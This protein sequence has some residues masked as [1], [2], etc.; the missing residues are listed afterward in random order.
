MN[1]QFRLIVFANFYN[2]SDRS[3]LWLFRSNENFPGSQK[4]QTILSSDT[5]RHQFV[6]GCRRIKQCSSVCLDGSRGHGQALQAP[7]EHYIRPTLS[8]DQPSRK[9]RRQSRTNCK[10]RASEQ[11]LLYPWASRSRRRLRAATLLAS[12]ERAS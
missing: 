10:L 9:R 8:D 11:Q 12:A 7:E 1:R 2:F 6:R 5:S 4:I 3:A